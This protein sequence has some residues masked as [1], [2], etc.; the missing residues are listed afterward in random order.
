MTPSP[1]SRTSARGRSGSGSSGSH[2]LSRRGL[3]DL[4]S[5]HN[6][7]PRKS[8]GQHFLADPNIARLIARESGAGAGDRVLEIGPG[9]GSLTLALAET[10]AE[11]LALEVDERVIPALQEAISGVGNVRVR[12][13]DA[14]RADWDAVL[15][16]GA[17]R[18]ASNLP[19]NIATA[20][21]IDLLRQAPGVDP[22]LVMVQREVGE[23]LVASPGQEAFG[24]VSL[25]V[26]YRAESKLL[27]RVRASVFWPEPQVESVLVRISRRPPPVSPPEKSLFRLIEAGFA[28]RRKTMANALVRLGYE[29]RLA[30]AALV[31]AGLDRR[32]RA[33][34]LG[35]EEFARLVQALGE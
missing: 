13:V 28:Q 35:L 3:R 19:Y 24:A 15:G 5:R 8:L 29:R 12:I 34:E 31:E 25:R 26:A 32:V 1:G 16:P 33:E 10:G 20:V 14:A 23:R 21:V 27:R 4:A 17:W 22:M 9:L 2:L 7:R 30:A 6:I 18:M 11:V